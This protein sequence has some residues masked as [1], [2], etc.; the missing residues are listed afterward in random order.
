MS[1]EYDVPSSDDLPTEIG[2]LPH[3]ENVENVEMQNSR[4][5]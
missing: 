2:E 1:H 4:V 5:N 3:V